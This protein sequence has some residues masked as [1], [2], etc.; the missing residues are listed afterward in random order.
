M[1]HR[2]TRPHGLPQTPWEQGPQGP[3]AGSADGVRRGGGLLCPPPAVAQMAYEEEAEVQGPDFYRGFTFCCFVVQ[4]P[5]RLA[6]HGVT[7]SPLPWN[8]KIG[9]AALPGRGVVRTKRKAPRKSLDSSHALERK[10]TDITI[11]ISLL[12]PTK[13]FLTRGKCNRV[14]RQVFSGAKDRNHQVTQDSCLES[15]CTRSADGR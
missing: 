6:R 1:S 4:A 9:T 7:P 15:I 3:S 11:F 10:K 13:T 8:G 12:G 14:N 5:D 2:A